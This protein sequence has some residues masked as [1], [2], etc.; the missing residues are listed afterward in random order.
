MNNDD[1][2]L[3]TGREQRTKPMADNVIR[4]SRSLGAIN[5]NSQVSNSD[6]RQDQ[7]KSKKLID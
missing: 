3:S 5:G 1:E 4:S 7:I 2:V 6:K